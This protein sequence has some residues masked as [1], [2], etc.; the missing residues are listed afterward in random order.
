MRATGAA[1]GPSVGDPTIA[2][3]LYFALVGL[4]PIGQGD[5]V[6]KPPESLMVHAVRLHGG[7][8][9][10]GV[11]SEPD[12]ATAIPVSD[13]TQREP[14]EGTIATERTEVR[15]LYDND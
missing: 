10:D 15:V 12:W 9:L 5:T 6:P 13:F 1:E 11:L 4:T 7:F 3:A 8:T 14:H 2:V